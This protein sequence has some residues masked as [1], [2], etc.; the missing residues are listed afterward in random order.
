MLGAG[1][2]GPAAARRVGGHH[3]RSRHRHSRHPD[4]SILHELPIPVKGVYGVSFSPDGRLLAAASADKIVR[5]WQTA[6]Q[7]CG[8]I[9]QLTTRRG[10]PGQLES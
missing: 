8:A 2:T 3:L 7:R 5:V 4:G 1:G 9:G 10:R 6:D